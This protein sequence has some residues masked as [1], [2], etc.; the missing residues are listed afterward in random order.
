MKDIYE[1]LND[2]T[3]DDKEYEEMEVT[4]LEKAK[5]KSTLKKSMI[6]KKK[7]MGWKTNVAAAAMVVGLSTATLALAFPAYAG[8]IPVIGDIFRFLDN[9]KTGMYDSYKE[10][11]TELNLTQESKG[12]KMTINDAVFDGKTV[13][14]TYS[15][16]SSHDLGEM[17]ILPDMPDIKGTDGMLGASHISKIDDT[18][19]VGLNKFTPVDLTSDTVDVKWKVNSLLLQDTDQEIKGNWDF[20]FSLKATDNQVLLSNESAEQHGIRVSVEKIVFTPMSFIVHYDHKVSETAREKWN[21]VDVEIE[22]RDDLGN[23]Y[24][25]D[26][27]EGSGQGDLMS[28]SKTFGKQ[29]D[30]NATQ[31]IVTPT[32][33]LSNIDHG[34]GGGEA[35]LKEN[36][37]TET[38]TVKTKA[39]VV[40]ETFTEESMMAT[41]EFET[42]KKEFIM[43][44]IIIELKK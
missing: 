40:G 29:L 36:G 7:R 16:E 22:V 28:W 1:L 13:A 24:T 15:I 41:E 30:P 25:G 32:V 43:E 35:L 14:I 4:E 8:N 20:A 2:V 9:D 10:F 6:K 39:T 31:L 12:I 27:Y 3:I 37:D 34:D 33:Y 23:I 18:H 44:D 21:S 19:Y 38:V 26:G 11:S 5:V 17:L 42:E